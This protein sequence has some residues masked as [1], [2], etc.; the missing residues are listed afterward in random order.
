ML[1]ATHGCILRVW[2]GARA[3]RTKG[4]EMLKQASEVMGKGAYAV[5]SQNHDE[6]QAVRYAKGEVYSIARATVSGLIAKGYGVV[7]AMPGRT[8][9]ACSDHSEACSFIIAAPVRDMKSAGLL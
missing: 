5:Y 9:L 8:E 4:T 3:S 1:L 6:A 7:G 2:Q